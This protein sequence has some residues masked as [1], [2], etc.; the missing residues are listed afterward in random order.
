MNLPTRIRTARRKAD[1]SQQ[2]LAKCLDVSR[3]AVSNWEGNGQARP[4]IDNLRGIAEVT[5]TSFDWLA[6]GRGSIMP[7]ASTA[8][9]PII[10]SPE[11][12]DPMETRLLNLFRSI[13]FNK[14]ARFL[15]AITAMLVVMFD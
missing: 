7:D 14:R 12:C 8:S 11:A 2:A 3:G 5:K 4:S 6:T 9:A 10:G 13:S 1:L 15:E